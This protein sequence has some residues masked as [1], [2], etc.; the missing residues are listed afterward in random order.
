MTGR[1]ELQLDAE[2]SRVFLDLFG[3]V[4]GVAI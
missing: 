4:D 2:A 1:D 3:A